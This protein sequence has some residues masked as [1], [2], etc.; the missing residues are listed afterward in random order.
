MK[1]LHQVKR[2]TNAPHKCGAVIFDLLK[3]RLEVIRKSNPSDLPIL[4]AAY[5]YV[6]ENYETHPTFSELVSIH[7][8]FFSYNIVDDG[9]KL[10]I[11]D[12]EF[13]DWGTPYMDMASLMVVDDLNFEK[14]ELALNTYF[15]TPTSVD[16]QCLQGT[17]LIYRLS[18]VL[19][20]K[21]QLLN[22]QDA[23]KVKYQNFYDLHMKRFWEQLALIKKDTTFPKNLKTVMSSYDSLSG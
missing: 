19:Y 14:I 9:E 6:K 15:E 2:K 10:R 12:W 22:R 3:N 7:G 5:A 16:R 21:L 8:D 18:S 1:G 20:F 23:R 17:A 13:S 4:E 11:I